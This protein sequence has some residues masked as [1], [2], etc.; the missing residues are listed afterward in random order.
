M[1]HHFYRRVALVEGAGNRA[2]AVAIQPQGELGHVVGADGET[3]EVFE[4]LLG[5]HGVGG[6]LAHHNQA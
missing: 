1:Q 6:Q 4:E 5:Q 2:A 3:V